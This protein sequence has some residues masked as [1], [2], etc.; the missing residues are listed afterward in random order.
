[1]YFNDRLWV[2]KQCRQAPQP[3]FFLPSMQ[4]PCHHYYL[5]NVQSDH[6]WSIRTGSNSNICRLGSTAVPR[7]SDGNQIGAC[8]V[9]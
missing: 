7:W 4:L 3:K 9:V 2:A 1:M 5:V 8:F 6:V